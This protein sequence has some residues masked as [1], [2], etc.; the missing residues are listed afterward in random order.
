MAKKV[1]LNKEE[2]KALVKDLE[3]EI[4]K[5]KSALVKLE[6]SAGILQTGDKN[7][8]YWNGESAIEFNKSLLGHFDH[9]RNLLNSL[10]KSLDYLKSLSK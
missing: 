3:S 6:T 9:D 1:D 7:G 5:F 2:I 8:P 10:E 4:K